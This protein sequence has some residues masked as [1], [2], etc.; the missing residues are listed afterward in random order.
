MN[1]I[2]VNEEILTREEVMDVLKL[3]EVYF[4]SSWNQAI[5]KDLKKA[6]VTKFQQKQ[7][8]ITL[9]I[10]WHLNKKSPKAFGYFRAFLCLYCCYVGA[11]E[12]WGTGCFP[13]GGNVWAES[14]C[15]KYSG[16]GN[17]NGLQR[18][19]IW[20]G[21]SRLFLL[22]CLCIMANVGQKRKFQI[23][24]GDWSWFWQWCSVPYIQ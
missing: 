13:E 3:D 11:L 17:E 9:H 21:R 14:S 16:G 6:I 18:A 4:T 24:T 8:Q 5:W 12:E 20:S 23:P 10:K 1:H 22:S 19:C 2:F 7:S 15:S